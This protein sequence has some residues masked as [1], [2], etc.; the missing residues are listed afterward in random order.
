MARV[1]MNSLL[2]TN[3]SCCMKSSLNVIFS[4]LELMISLLTSSMSLCYHLSSSFENT[5]LCNSYCCICSIEFTWRVRLTFSSR[6][7][8]SII[9]RDIMVIGDSLSHDTIQYFRRLEVHQAKCNSFFRSSEINKL[10]S[11]IFR[12]TKIWYLITNLH[13]FILLSKAPNP[14]S[15]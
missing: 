11:F 5:T 9:S 12:L 2:H 7:F 3:V 8:R 10:I 15:T 14:P 1:F 6:I 13:F 4:I